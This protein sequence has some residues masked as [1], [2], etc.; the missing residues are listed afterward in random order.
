MNVP[1][2]KMNI[3][4]L[5][6]YSIAE[7]HKDDFSYDKNNFID[8]LYGSDILRNSINSKKNIN[9]I[10]QEWNPFNNEKYLLY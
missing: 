7:N 5:F 6:K 4:S 2:I 10:I 9:E 1:Q 8:K 3:L